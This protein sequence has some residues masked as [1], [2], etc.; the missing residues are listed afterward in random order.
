MT[1]IYQPLDVAINGILKCKASKI[2]SA[3]IALN[4]EKI[5]THSQCLT[6]FLIIMKEIK[7]G[8]IMRS[9]IRNQHFETSF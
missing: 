3:F 1:S 4:P 5:Y 6:D 8:S 7:K 9:F 2:Y